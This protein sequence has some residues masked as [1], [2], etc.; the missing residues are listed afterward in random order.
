MKWNE[1]SIK[2][3]NQVF[4]RLK[5]KQELEKE[6][7]LLKK[8]QLMLETD[9]AAKFNILQEYEASHTGASKQGDVMVE[10]ME[11]GQDPFDTDAN[12]MHRQA[13]VLTKQTSSKEYAA[14]RTST[15]RIKIRKPY[16]RR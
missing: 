1:S 5:R 2:K 8:E 6:E 7:A 11:K 3:N 15:V 14:K 16:L 9:I 4:K 10:Y 12:E 13:Q